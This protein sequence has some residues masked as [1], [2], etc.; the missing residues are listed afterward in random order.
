MAELQVSRKNIATL[1]KM[2]DNGYTNKTYVIPEYQRPYRWEENECDTLW[3]DVVNFYTALKEP[4]APQEYFLGTI[5]TC[6]DEYNANE[7]DI[8]DGQQR[9]TSLLLLLRAFRKKLQ[10]MQEDAPSDDNV[11]GLI[12]QIDPCIW[13]TSE[14]SGKVVDTNDLKIDSRVALD[15]DNDDFKAI[16]STGKEKRTTSSYNRNYVF[17]LKK[18]DEFAQNHPMDW[19]E[20]CL[21]ILNRCIVLPIECNDLNSA[22][23]IFGTLNNRGLPLSDSDIFKAELYKLRSTPQEKTNFTEDWKQLEETVSEADITINDVFRFYT[24]VLRARKEI[25]ENEMGLRRFYAGDDFKYKAFKEEHFFDD[26][27]ALAKFWNTF[28]L[29]ARKFDADNEYS[30]EEA[31][32]FAQCLITYPNDYW[33]CLVTVYFFK[34]RQD[35]DF[36]AGLEDFL[37]RMTAYMYVLFVVKPMVNEVKKPT[38]KLCIEVEK[39]G[40][41]TFRYNIPEDFATRMDLASQSLSKIVK[42]LILLHTYLYNPRQA[43]ITGRLEIEHILPKRWKKANYNGW[44][45]EDANSLLESIGNKIPFEKR[46]NIQA[47][48]GYFGEKKQKYVQSPIVEVQKLADHDSNDWLK[49]DIERRRDDLCER[50]IAFFTKYLNVSMETCKTEELLNVVKK[51]EK[52]IIRK[53]TAGDEVVSYQVIQDTI[54]TLT[55]AQILSGNITVK[56]TEESYSTLGEAL[57]HINTAILVSPDKQVMTDEVRNAIMNV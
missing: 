30:T 28:N 1:L 32:K 53:I 6:T 47:G 41:A 4:K 22:L 15:K 2:T 21:C 14:M 51:Q 33:R 5:V 56:H 54:G 35:E 27:L 25:S 26:I 39:T 3:T 52:T 46:L 44:N 19:K 8:I 55:A 23:T 9:I 29:N 20:L 40:N 57:A 7:I 45:R 38:Y 17:F 37:R 11:T 50:L 48:N 36:K 13:R 10:E 24:H 31:A 34:H 16:L 18:C 42:P 12:R 49:E 43:L